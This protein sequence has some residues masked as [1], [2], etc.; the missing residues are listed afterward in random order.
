MA[1]APSLSVPINRRRYNPATCASI[2]RGQ[3]A[4]ERQH[5][6][7]LPPPGPAGELI[8]PYRRL[9]V[10]AEQQ[11]GIA[12]CGVLDIG[13]VQGQMLQRHGQDRRP[14]MSASGRV[15]G[16]GRAKPWAAPTG[17]TPVRRPRR[18]P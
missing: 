11:H 2:M 12:D 14:R 5:R 8:Q 6:I 15:P 4:G 3:P 16:A 17:A 13:K 7:E 9:A 10:P 18:I 1:G